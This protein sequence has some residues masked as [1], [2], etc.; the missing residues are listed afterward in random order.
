MRRVAKCSGCG[1]DLDPADEEDFHPELCWVCR[2]NEPTE[3]DD[4]P[5]Q[6]GETDE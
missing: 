2:L 5:E 3:D 6:E 4:E 1:R